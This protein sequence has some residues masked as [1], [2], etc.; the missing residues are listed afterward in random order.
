MQRHTLDMAP[1]QALIET[2]DIGHERASA[3]RRQ[4]GKLYN[5]LKHRTLSRA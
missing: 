5:V 1:R 2:P 3:D 4:T